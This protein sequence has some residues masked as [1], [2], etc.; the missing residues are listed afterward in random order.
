MNR[1]ATW[2]GRNVVD[3]DLIAGQ[4]SLVAEL[5][6]DCHG[7]V[8]LHVAN[9]GNSNPGDLRQIDSSRTAPARASHSSA[10]QCSVVLDLLLW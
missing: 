3:E 10:M 1:L 6:G 9:M 7:V 5:E 4:L 8:I 2:E